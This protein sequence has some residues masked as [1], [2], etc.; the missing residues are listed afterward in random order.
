MRARV[1]AGAREGERAFSVGRGEEA[2]K[3]TGGQGK[4]AAGRRMGK[5]KS[6]GRMNPPRKA[7]RRARLSCPAASEPVLEADFLSFSYYYVI[8]T[9][10]F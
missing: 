3:H 1:Y 8:G 9:F 10:S 6:F 4:G 5:T 7:A 2:L